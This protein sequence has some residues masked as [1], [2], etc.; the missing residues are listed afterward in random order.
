MGSG[1]FFR[2]SYEKDGKAKGKQKRRKGKLQNWQLIPKQE[3]E[4]TLF[5]SQTSRCN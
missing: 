1:K 2:F 5:F 4:L 3:E